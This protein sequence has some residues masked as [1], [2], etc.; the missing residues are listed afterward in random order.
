MK[1]YALEP[2]DTQA[3]PSPYRRRYWKAITFVLSRHYRKA[4][5]F[6]LSRHCRN[7]AIDA[8]PAPIVYNP[9]PC[10]SVSVYPPTRITPKTPITK[11]LILILN[12]RYL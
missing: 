3:T 1:G 10:T 8:A 7:G 4:N 9:Y 12:L 2:H 11:A 5:A 6:A